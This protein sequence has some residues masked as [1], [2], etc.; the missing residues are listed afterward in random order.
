MANRRG[1]YLL[2]QRRKAALHKAQLAS[3]KKRRGRRKR[4]AAG[5]G[6]GAGILAVTAVGGVYAY[7]ISYRKKSK[8]IENMVAPERNVI[9]LPIER[10]KRP[11]L[12]LAPRYKKWGKPGSKKWKKRKADQEK[13][14]SKRRMLYW[15]GRK[16]R[17][18]QY[19]ENHRGDGKPHLPKPVGKD[20]RK[21]K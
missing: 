17:A 8:P 21:R 2:T 5:L 19:R 4:V 15:S 1:K 12:P 14:N 10:R 7:K 3:A 6:A 16:K 18:R 11:G 9:E 13:Y 20:L